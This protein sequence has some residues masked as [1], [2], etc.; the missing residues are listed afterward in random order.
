MKILVTGATGFI[1]QRLV[2]SSL[3]ESYQIA[4]IVRENSDTSVLGK[5]IKVFHYNENIDKLIKFCT[6]EK[7]DGVIHL[8]THFTT[9]HT[10]ED[11]PKLIVSNVKFGTE[12]IEAAIQ[13]KIKWM[14]NVG[15]FW[16]NFCSDGYNP[17]NLYAATKE[18]FQT[19]AK[20]YTETSDLIFTTIKL[21]DTY[22]PNDTR[23][24]LINLWNKIAKTGESVDF[25]E[26]NQI[27]DISYIDD[28]I[29]AFEILIKHLYSVDCHNFK[30]KIFTVSAKERVTL[31]EL[32]SI[33]EKATKSKLHINWG[34]RPYRKREVMVPWDKSIPIPGW[35]PKYSLEMGF[36]ELMKQQDNV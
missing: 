7:F 34:K 11:I 20:Y 8:A 32:A 15:T 23:K 3:R 27:M 24:K 6:Y 14:I 28:V 25:P 13:T 19:I 21:N 2:N 26:G 17:A 4:V 29:S 12:I 1:G 30:N 18:A 16:Q 9:N 5:G 33:Y 22:G 36:K 35:N 31:K 10:T